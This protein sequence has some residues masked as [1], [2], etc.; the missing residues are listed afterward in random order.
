MSIASANA[1]SLIQDC[2]PKNFDSFNSISTELYTL[3]NKEITSAALKSL[4]VGI[5]VGVVFC[6]GCKAWNYY[7]HKDNPLENKISIKQSALI[8]T[9]ALLA[10]HIFSVWI[11]TTHVV[12]TAIAG[13]AILGMID[14]SIHQQPLSSIPT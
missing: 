5:T 8:G 9:T 7:N 3:I 4:F 13:G 1:S 12:S 14:V 2:P 6:L 10:S 11:F